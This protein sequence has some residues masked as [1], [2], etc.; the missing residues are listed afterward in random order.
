MQPLQ[1]AN[2]PSQQIG[3]FMLQSVYFFKRL[4]YK[5]RHEMICT[6]NDGNFFVFNLISAGL[7]EKKYF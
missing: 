4:K 2:L 7:G 5:S 3:L 6:N 1:V